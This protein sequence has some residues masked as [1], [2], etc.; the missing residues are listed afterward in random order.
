[1]LKN[2]DMPATSKQLW[3]LHILTKSDTRNLKLTMLEASQQIESLKSGKSIKSVNSKPIENKPKSTNEIEVVQG[4]KPE[5]KTDLD[6]IKVHFNEHA[7]PLAI[8]KLIKSNMPTDNVDIGFYEFN[9]KDCLFGQTGICEPNWSESAFT[10]CGG[11]VTDVSFSCRHYEPTIQH[12]SAYCQRPKGK[13]CHR[14]SIEN[15]C[16]NCAYRSQDGH[17]YGSNRSIWYDYIPTIENRIKEY[18]DILKTELNP[19]ESF[20]DL[21]YTDSIQLHQTILRLLNSLLTK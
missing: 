13:Q 21:D 4:I 19:P 10:T 17:Y 2:P 1:M 16:L 15:K 14:K 6:K 8:E 9:C 12:P 11:I 7:K 3:L 20:K 18:T 5:N